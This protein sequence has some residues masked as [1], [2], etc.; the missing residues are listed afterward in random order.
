MELLG[1]LILPLDWE[2]PEGKN[3]LFKEFLYG[4]VG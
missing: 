2:L 1:S 4:S 3:K